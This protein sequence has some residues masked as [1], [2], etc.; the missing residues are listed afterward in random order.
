MNDHPLVTKLICVAV[1]ASIIF[2]AG[3][4]IFPF[5]EPTI[6]ELL[7]D[8]AEAVLSATLGFALDTAMFG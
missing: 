1:V 3:R 2:A 7:F 6:G 8:V 5:V 4:V